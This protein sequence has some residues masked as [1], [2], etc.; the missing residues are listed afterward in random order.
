MREGGI[1][2]RECAK[3]GFKGGGGGKLRGRLGRG[4]EDEEH[5]KLY[6]GTDWT[7]RLVKGQNGGRGRLP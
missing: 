6:T 7:G 2:E 3:Q 4:W 5:T 1:L